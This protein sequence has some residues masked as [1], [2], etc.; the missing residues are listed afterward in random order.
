VNYENFVKLASKNILDIYNYSTENSYLLKNFTDSNQLGVNIPNKNNPYFERNKQNTSHIQV[1]DPDNYYYINELGLRGKINYESDVLTAGCAITFGLGIPEEGTWPQLLSKKI[2]RDVIN[3]G[4][5]GFTIRKTCDLVIRYSS[6]YKIP[7]TIFVLFPNLFRTMLV[8]DVDFYATTKN[9][10]PNKQRK[11]WKQEGFD[12]GILFNKQNNFIS[13]KH[14]NKPGYFESKNRDVNY[15]ENVL[16]PHQLIIDAVDAI[17]TLESFCSSHNIDLYW[18]I[19]HTPSA[20]LMDHLLKV[21]N[22]KL[23]R[24]FRFAD[25]NFNSYF[26]K[27]GKISN[28][29]CNLDHNSEFIN[30]PFWKQG[31]DKCIDIND[32]ILEKWISSPGIHFHHHVAELF[33]EVYN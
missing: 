12:A 32:N 6:K 27:D 29:F 16:S 14:T 17:S 22:F 28:K 10:Y 7:K 1:I 19:W 26:G 11:T 9:M 8:E 18:S 33:N 3:L 31:S 23:K 13:F 2:N 20:L 5:P 4:N 24:Y 30:H 21:P 15:M 25:D